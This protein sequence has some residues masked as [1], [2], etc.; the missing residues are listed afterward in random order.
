M[1]RNVKYSALGLITVFVVVLTFGCPPAPKLMCSTNSLSLS[2]SQLQGTFEV[3]NAGGG[4]L[5]FSVASSPA[6]LTSTP[7]SGTSTGTGDKKTITVQAP[8]TISKATFNGTVTVSS[9]YGTQT[10]QVSVD[11]TDGKLVGWVQDIDGVHLPGVAVTLSVANKFN[12]RST[13]TDANGLYSIGGLPT[14]SGLRLTFE[15]DGYTLNS[16]VVDVIESETTSANTTLKLRDAAQTVD[17]AGAITATDATGETKV[18]LPAGALVY[19][20]TKGPVTGDVDVSVTPLDVSNF[21]EL[22][23]FPGN[24]QA[25]TSNKS[26]GV[27]QLET[28]GLAEVVIDTPTGEEVTLA[29]KAVA[30]MEIKLPADTPLQSGDVVPAWYFDEAQSL[31]VQA[32]DGLVGASTP[33][34]TGLSYF[35]EVDHFS[36]WNCDYPI[37]TKHCLTGR[38]LD[39]A[40]NPVAGASIIATGLS[41]SGLSYATTDVNGDFCVDVKRG[42]TVT[43]DVTPPG[44]TGPVVTQTVTVPDVEASCATGGCTDLGDLSAVYDSCVSGQVLNAAQQP[45]VGVEVFSSVGVT[46]VTDSN[47]EFCMEAPADTDVSLFTLGRPAVTVRTGTDQDCPDCEFVVL[48]L[49]YPADG[50]IVGI[51]VAMGLAFEEH[52][53]DKALIEHNTVISAALFAT[54]DEQILNMAG[55]NVITV[56]DMAPETC[57]VLTLREWFLL[58]GLDID[59]PSESAWVTDIA[60]VGLDPGA[61]GTISNAA[62][63]EQSMD[64]LR[65]WDQ[66]EGYDYGEFVVTL[67]SFTYGLFTNLFGFYDEESPFYISV[68]ADFDSGGDP[69]LSASFYW[70]GGA[71]IGEFYASV[72][73]PTQIEVTAPDI[74]GSDLGGVFSYLGLSGNIGEMDKLDLT[75]DLNVSWT[76]PGSKSID[77][78]VQVVLAVLTASDDEYT[79]GSWSGKVVHCKADH[80]GQFTIPASFLSELPVEPTPG[81]EV[82]YWQVLGVVAVAENLAAVPLVQTADGEGAVWLS[83]QNVPVLGYYDSYNGKAS[84]SLCRNEGSPRLFGIRRE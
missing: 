82:Y 64:M 21:A 58:M 4:T 3:W 16:H 30:Q 27:V 14:M 15:K 76:P 17:G 10:V 67:P 34:A 13:M 45:V 68:P 83:G 63:P 19:V 37:D 11:R 66:Y 28:F 24:M 46:A 26:D 75:Q 5:S 25:V 20:A 81:S 65:V 6:W 51:I 55:S 18:T 42:S 43:I 74:T 32:G 73:L 50:E 44:A 71:D 78:Y 2:E 69:I 36:W 60:L 77:P 23:A 57:E 70:P 39:G 41:Y 54:G 80:D 47:G 49:M 62:E 61:P 84:R 31:W 72:D 9:S 38:V 29:A 79:L 22:D 7:P 12:Q 48:D 8:E 33:P 1:S 35:F 52:M 59:D 53:L 40:G 56:R